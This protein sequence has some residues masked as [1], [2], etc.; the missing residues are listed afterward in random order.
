MSGQIFRAYR[1]V[2]L[3]KVRMQKLYTGKKGREKESGEVEE[4]ELTAAHRQPDTQ[5]ELVL[6]VLC[7]S[8]PSKGGKLCLKF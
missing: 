7:S 8:D 1:L 3:S 6:Q 2:S 4:Q 5:L